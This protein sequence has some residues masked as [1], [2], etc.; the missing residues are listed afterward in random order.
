MSESKS[1]T[2][3]MNTG[4]IFRMMWLIAIEQYPKLAVIDD[5]NYAHAILACTTEEAQDD[6]LK[7]FLESKGGTGSSS[8]N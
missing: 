6:V 8:N 1:F 7:R 4:D 5:D 3:N 2:I